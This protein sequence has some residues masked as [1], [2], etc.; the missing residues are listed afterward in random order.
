MN[1]PI[2]KAFVLGAGLGTRLKTLTARTPK[3]LLP[4]F[5]KP[6]ITFAFDHLIRNG[7]E[8]FVINTHHCPECYTRIF[9]EHFY[10]G[11]PLHFEH[12][13][14]LLETAGGIKNVERLLR[15][16]T[17]I[18]YNGDIL[19]D[20]PI[21][22]AVSQHFEQRN[23][24]TLI[25]R[26]SGAPLHIALEGSRVVD[27][28]G[29]L[30]AKADGHYMFTGIYI[31]SPSFLVKIPSRTKI[32]VIPIFM[33]MIQKNQKLGG[34]V[35]DEG[36]WWDLGTRESYLEVHRHLAKQPLEFEIN[37][38]IAGTWPEFIH[39][40]AEISS[41]AKISGATSIGASAF[42]SPGVQ[43]HD[44]IIWEHARVAPGAVLNNCIVTSGQT[45]SGSHTD[46]DF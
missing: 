15:N 20:L 8:Q 35:I 29:R 46:L 45:A 32:S 3:P 39:P 10:R 5:G 6:L 44:C 9:P 34:I 11:L 25:L 28:A 33:N 41:S 43:L 18:V 19:S 17:F 7:A 1:A 2:R 24:V 27:I 37:P 38:R 36:H 14:T 13:P 12:E 21:E 23:D 30:R 4:I 42:I 31:V 22:R 40:S 26:S 16:D